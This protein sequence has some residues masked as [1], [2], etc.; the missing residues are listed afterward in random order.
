MYIILSL[1]LS[2]SLTFCLSI[3]LFL[4]FFFLTH[5]LTFSLSFFSLSH[6]HTH[7]HTISLS[8]SFSLSQ[9]SH[10][11]I[12]TADAH[13]NAPNSPDAG[14]PDAHD[15]AN[16]RHFH[17]ELN[18]NLQIAPRQFLIFSVVVI[19]LVFG[20]GLHDLAYM[21]SSVC[22]RAL[23][24]VAV[25]CSVLQCVA[26]CIVVLNMRIYLVCGVIL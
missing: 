1:S 2:L 6:A 8:L 5:S 19:S 17:M 13:T 12:P 15:G 18:L 10:D 3:C 23:Q 22:C 20:T 25:C 9:S 11:D 21:S 16:R 7:T 4:Y 24:C 14:G 26:M